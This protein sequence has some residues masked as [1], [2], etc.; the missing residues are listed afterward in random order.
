[1]TSK[2]IMYRMHEGVGGCE[3]PR[4]I[5]AADLPRTKLLIVKREQCIIVSK[6]LLL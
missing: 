3:E 4:V 5:Y 1:M 6:S 2:Y